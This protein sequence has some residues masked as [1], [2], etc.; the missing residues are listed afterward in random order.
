[1][2]FLQKIQTKVLK[3]TMAGAKRIQAAHSAMMI[4]TLT[5]LPMEVRRM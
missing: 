2:F 1:M 4:F 5:P 3:M